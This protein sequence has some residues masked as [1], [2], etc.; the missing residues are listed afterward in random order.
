MMAGL[1]RRWPGVRLAQ[2]RLS[3]EIL[4]D[5]DPHDPAA[6]RSRRDLERV[7]LCMGTRCIIV[8]WVHTLLRITA[9]R[10]ADTE[11]PPVRILELGAGDGRLMLRV[12]RALGRRL[13]AVDFVMLDRQDI[14]TEQ[15]IEAYATMNWTA[16]T[17]ILDA[18]DWAASEACRDEQYDLI[19]TTLFLHHFDNDELDVLLQA[20]AF[21]STSSLALEPRRSLLASAG[22]RLVG[23]LGANSVTRHDA[24]VSVQAGFR[25][26]ELSERWPAASKHWTLVE[27][28]AGPFGHVFSASRQ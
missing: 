12:A 26:R 20:M 22:S 13:G 19:I 28:A 21:I 1:Q 6:I 27:R 15:T 24:V 8:Y 23:L 5:L 2:R 11:S 17:R 4:D 14:I 16:C 10:G 18:L 25:D 7:H 3:R 9:V